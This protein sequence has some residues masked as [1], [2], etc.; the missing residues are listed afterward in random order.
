MARFKEHNIKVIPVVP[1]VALAKEWKN[2]CRCCHFE[3]MEAGGHIGKL[4]TMVAYRK[5]LTLCQFL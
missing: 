4:T 1:S 2:W 3:G 5:S